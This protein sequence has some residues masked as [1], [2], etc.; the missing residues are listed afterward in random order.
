ME[1]VQ[2]GAGVQA[3]LLDQLVAELALARQRLGLPAG[4]VESSQLGG[5]EPFPE[6]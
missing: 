2:L 1:R 3:Q 4:A 6:G 5:A